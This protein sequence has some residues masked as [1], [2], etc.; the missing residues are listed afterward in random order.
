MNHQPLVQFVKELENVETVAIVRQENLLNAVVAGG[1]TLI[2]MIG[3]SVT[4][5]DNLNS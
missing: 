2:P 1:T 4:T 3:M 5:N